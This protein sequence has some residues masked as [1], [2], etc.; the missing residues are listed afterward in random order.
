MRKQLLTV[1]LAGTMTLLSLLI[2]SGTT[3]SAFAMESL[4]R[5]TQAVAAPGPITIGEIGTP[6]NTDPPQHR[7]HGSKNDLPERR[8]ATSATYRLDDGRYATV[9]T[10]HPLNYRDDEGQWQPIDPRFTKSERG[11]MSL[12]NNVKTSLALES[13]RAKVW[14]GQ[15]GVGWDPQKLVAASNAGAG[16]ILMRCRPGPG[17]R[18]DGM[19]AW[20]V[21][22]L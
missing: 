6:Q 20:G 10:T 11:W 7:E 17:N 2:Q 4:P 1:A 18:G 9:M 21:Q 8:T 5:P 14:A 3:P 15:N 13:S 16:R 22:I 12:R 19:R